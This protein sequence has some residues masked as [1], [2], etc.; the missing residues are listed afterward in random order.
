MKQS[1]KKMIVGLSAACIL[2]TSMPSL[3]APHTVES[4]DTFWKISQKYNVSFQQLMAVNK[5]TD[6]TILYVG[7]RLMIPDGDNFYY[8]QVQ[9][10][11][12]PWKIS[13]KY[14]IPLK[15]FL[16]FNKMTEAAVIYVGQKVQ[17]PI[18]TTSTNT[19]TT[20]TPVPAPVPT[21]APEPTPV[22]SQTPT[23]TYQNY[24][25]KSGDNFWSI[26]LRYGIPYQEIIKANNMTSSTM[27]SIGQ[28]LKIPVHNVPI[29]STPGSAYGEHLDWWTGAQYV[30]P[31]GATFKV[32]DFNTGKSFMA[33]RTTGAN[34]ADVETLTTQDTALLKEIWGGNF[35][36]TSRPVLIE[37]NGRKIAASAS[38]MPH[39]GNDSA[40]A[41]VYTT[42][43]SDSYGPG[44]NYDYIKGN[45]M[46]GHFDIH[47]LNSTRHKD[48]QIDLQHQVNIKKA[49]GI[50]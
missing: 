22:L 26:S 15:S 31:V 27:L 8:H 30:V 32:I 18:S 34:H 9:Q 28:V 41:E 36:W 37:Y 13:V 10:G 46:D 21:Q 40:P 6:S 45:G 47:F 17:I 44:A 11:D 49:A 33:K 12:T 5:A 24:T 50:Q 14:G 38:S 39:A 19:T 43:R 1:I 20:T 7:T 35:S 4:G 16:E 42:W 29:M 48:G 3:A 25:V 23:V 2:S